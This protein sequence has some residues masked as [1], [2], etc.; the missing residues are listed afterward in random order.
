MS[1]IRSISIALDARSNSRIDYVR[2]SAI[3]IGIQNL[4]NGFTATVAAYDLLIK[5]NDLWLHCY[6]HRSHQAID[7]QIPIEALD[8][9]NSI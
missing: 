2:V 8:Q 1:G 6:Y 7:N 9:E 5:M 3:A 4:S